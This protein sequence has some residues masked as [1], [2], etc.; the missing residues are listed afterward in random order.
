MNHDAAGP[1]Q[2]ES[3]RPATVS[4]LRLPREIGI[5]GALFLMLVIL[6]LFIPQFRDIGNVINITR[7][8]SFVGIVAAGMMFMI[9]TSGDIF[10]IPNPFLIFLLVAIVGWI[11]LSRTVW[12]RYVYAVGWR[13]FAD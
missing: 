9:L 1:A 8:F 6:A 12:G 3:S 10:G 11:L 4:R 2:P 5:V 13:T 7:N